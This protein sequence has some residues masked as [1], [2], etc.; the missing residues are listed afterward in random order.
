MYSTLFGGRR[1]QSRSANHNGIREG[2]TAAAAFDESTY[3]A[4]LRS[5]S[6]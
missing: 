2:P 1:S 4:K 3:W 5:R 6:S